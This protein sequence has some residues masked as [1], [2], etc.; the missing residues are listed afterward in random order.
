[1]G[2]FVCE[3]RTRT[4]GAIG[5]FSGMSFVVDA[6]CV[7]A[8]RS[9]AIDLAHA[10]RLETLGCEGC[11]SAPDHQSKAIR[12]AVAAYET[13]ALWSSTNDDGEPLDSEPREFAP[14]TAAR[15]LHDCGRFMLD[16]WRLF[17]D[18]CEP[19]GYTADRLGHDLWLTRNGHGA[20]FWDRDELP[21]HARDELT[22]AAG[23]LGTADLYLGDDGEVHQS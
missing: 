15:M 16:N 19:A 18:A 14:E 12:A 23:S 21:Q 20:G 17:R 1:M 2:L 8:A 6:S 7:A 9:Q 22:A 10:M 11:R 3:A 13:C 5:V 4:Y